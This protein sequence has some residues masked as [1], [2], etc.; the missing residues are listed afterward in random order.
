M[1]QDLCVRVTGRYRLAE[2]SQVVRAYDSN[3]LVRFGVS[4]NTLSQNRTGLFDYLIRYCQ[5]LLA[6]GQPLY[7]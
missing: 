5:Y 1:L 7:A 2:S 6:K 4:F 3:T